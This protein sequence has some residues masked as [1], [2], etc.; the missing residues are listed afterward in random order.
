MLPAK[1]GH[2]ESG[3]YI[4]LDCFG[5]GQQIVLTGAEP[6]EP[7]FARNTFRSPH[8]LSQFW[9]IQVKPIQEFT[10]LQGKGALARKRNA[11]CGK[12]RQKVRES[13]KTKEK[14]SCGELPEL[15]ETARLATPLARFG[16][17]GRAASKQKVAG[18][19]PAGRA[20]ILNL[21]RKKGI[22]KT[23]V[24]PRSTAKSAEGRVLR[25]PEGL[26]FLS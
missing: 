3:S 25:A 9:D 22:R 14:V 21:I 11:S 15:A 19:S 12:Q 24:H 4:V 20:I 1:L 13:G 26:S 18:S 6:E 8:G 2:A 5:E 7:A 23:A 17:V 16:K 10:V